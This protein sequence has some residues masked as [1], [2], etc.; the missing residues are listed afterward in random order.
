MCIRDRRWG[1]PAPDR[2]SGLPWR[3]RPAWHREA[4]IALPPLGPEG[5][6]VR[7]EEL[8]LVDRALR[9]L[10]PQLLD[11]RLERLDRAGERAQLLVRRRL[12]RGGA[13][14]DL[15]RRALCLGE[16]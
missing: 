2:A 3:A 6:I 14:E 15:P 13:G 9:L 16:R 10:R 12:L 1:A 4:S 8:G 5:V 7:P 11:V